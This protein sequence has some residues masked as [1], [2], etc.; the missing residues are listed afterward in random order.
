MLLEVEDLLV[1]Y[2]TSRGTLSAVDGV[3][4]ALAR[5][6]TVGLVGESGCGKSS[7]GKAITRLVPAESGA[8]RLDGTDLAPLS[9]RAMKRH[10][11]RL[12]MMFQDSLSAFDP[13][14]SIGQS[15][16]QPLDVHRVGDRLSRQH[17]IDMRL[18]RV[19]LPASVQSRLP[20]EFSGGQRQRLNL[21]R[22][23]ML[24]P[25][26][27]VCDEPVAALDVSLQAQVLNL[28]REL[29][30]ELGIAYLFI[31]HDLAVVGYMAD[32]IAVMYLGVIVETLP[33]T[34]LWDASLHPYTQILIASVP[35]VERPAALSAPPTG[36]LPS[37]FSPPSG[38]R[39]RT[40]CPY[41]FAACDSAPPLREVE[42]AHWVACHLHAPL[43]SP[44]ALPSTTGARP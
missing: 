22:A 42:P 9:R 13:R 34:R 21:A 28:M 39:F 38:C 43:A 30:Q 11:P 41:A 1:R 5:G 12:Q 10:R 31:S 19:G 15:L 35:D 26:V 14:R 27:V 23:L 16:R 8:I 44:R 17:K 25:D 36:E 6:E 24:D 40:R 3:S 29:Q 2:R 37:P 18:E 7:L 33:R 32:R 4:I 20:H